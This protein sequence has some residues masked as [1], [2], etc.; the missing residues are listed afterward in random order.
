MLFTCAVANVLPL[1]AGRFLPF[2]DMPEHIAAI[3]A[4]GQWTDASFRIGEHYAFAIGE[5]QYL[6]Y[7]ALGAALA[8]VVGSPER[9]NLL[10]LLATGIAWPYATRSLLRALGRDDRLA[11]FACPI[12]WN[13]ALIVGLLPFVAS[14]PLCLYGLAVAVRTERKWIIGIIGVVLFVAHV[15]AFGIFVLSFA[16][17]TVLERR[18]KAR[19]LALVPGLVV[20]AGW[21]SS[22]RLATR[23]AD[24]LKFASPTV[25]ARGFPYW[26]HDTW[27]GH[28]EDVL[29]VAF[30]IV[31]AVVA[32]R[33][34]TKRIALWAPLVVVLAL[35]LFTPYRIGGG[36]ML[37]VRLAVFV[38]L[39]VLPLLEAP[40][41]RR[42][43]FVAAAAL[44]VLGAA[45]HAREIRLAQR[46]MGD[47]DRVLAAVPR[48]ARLLS[49]QFDRESRRTQF[50]PWLHVA[51]LHRA[52]NG[53]VAEPSFA[54]LGHWPIHYR[55]D[56]APPKKDIDFWEF[57]PE[58]FVN[59]VDGPYYDYVLV[60]G[61]VDPFDSASGPRWEAVVHEAPWTLW[62]RRPNAMT[63]NAT[64][65]AN[66][67]CRESRDDAAP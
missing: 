38:P 29:A 48:G 39:L 47:F 27:R 18:R 57:H 46:E 20:A 10:L 56:A 34:A 36:D 1:L 9:A 65:A 62:R 52:R 11:L 58:L 22:T 6:L 15:Q 50:P 4:F 32:L 2:S 41:K 59:E 26:A 40:E 45:N 42:W 54:V 14:V 28:G 8:R 19:L 21:L 64:N 63:A 66:A 12:F 13:H 67:P 49:L 5:S 31:I 51:A 43:P 16:A 55:E 61:D 3:A 35:F 44:T 25:I 33:G 17:I 30:W 24:Q 53:G 23:D 7:H 37:N 60:R